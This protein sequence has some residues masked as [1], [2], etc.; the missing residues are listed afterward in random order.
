MHEVEIR[1]GL[2]QMFYV[3]E[4]PWHGLGTKLED[5]PTVENAIYH[6]GLDW[7]VERVQLVMPKV[8]GNIPVPAYA[9][10]RSTDQKVLGIVGPTYRPLPNRDAFQWFQKFVDSNEVTLETAGSLREGKHVWI[11]ARVKQ[12][13]IEIVKNDPVAAYILLSNSHNGTASIRA[14]FTGIRAVCMNT[15]AAAH[16]AKSS[17]LVKVRHTEKANDALQGVREAMDLARQ[18]FVTTTEGM[19]A[20]ARRGVTVETLKQYVKAVFEPK[21]SLANDEE[22]Q[23]KL[24]RQVA[25]VIPLFESGRG[26]DVPGVRGTMWGAYNSVTELLTWERGRSNDTRLENLWLG[27]A[28]NLAQKAYNVAVRMAA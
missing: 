28:A 1:D 5:A 18:E 20:M 4:V 22:A 3:G 25:R 8:D 21:A 11:L 14:G 10:V 7:E 2:A 6:A 17:K 24:D 12:D 19:K 23:E 13:P 15:L 9:N 26:S 27:D 16:D